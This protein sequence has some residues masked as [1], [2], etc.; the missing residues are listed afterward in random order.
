MA[1]LAGA[2]V[3]VAMLV[4]AVGFF[5]YCVGWM[6]G[7]DAKL[8]AASVL[9]FGPN[10]IALEYGIALSF[11][12]LAVTLV[13]VLL[14]LDS[15]QYLLATNAVTRPFAGRDPSGRDTPYGL[16]ISAGALFMTP[17]LAGL[18]GVL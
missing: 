11:A 1:A 17:A 2:H 3:G 13:F 6:G 5:F 7:G 12:G 9:W 8:I 18:Y 4:F 14:R 16:A 10:L 15:A